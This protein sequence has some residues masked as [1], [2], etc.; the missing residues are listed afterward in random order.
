MREAYANWQTN[1]A[2]ATVVPPFDLPHRCDSEK[3]ETKNEQKKKNNEIAPEHLFLWPCL[4]RFSL[5]SGSTVLFYVGATI[6]VAT[7]SSFRT[8]N[9]LPDTQSYDFRLEH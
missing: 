3:L 5:S 8:E 2:A 4:T 7:H 1:G 6:C 9:L